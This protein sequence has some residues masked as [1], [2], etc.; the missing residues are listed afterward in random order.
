MRTPGSKPG[1][2]LR[3][4]SQLSYSAL[5]GRSASSLEE[6]G[7]SSRG[8]THATEVSRQLPKQDDGFHAR[9]ARCVQDRTPVSKRQI[10]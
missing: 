6:A 2:P 3:R 7:N 8:Y 1:A 5:D 10:G 9:T 4:W